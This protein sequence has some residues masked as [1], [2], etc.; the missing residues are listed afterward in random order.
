MSVEYILQIKNL[1]KK[2]RKYSILN[3]ISI[4]VRKNTIYALLGPNGAG[5]STTLKIISG[6]LK[7]TSGELIFNGRPWARKDL[8]SIGSL[9]E[10]APLY[11]NLTTTENLE[12]IRTI[13]NL[14]KK[15]IQ[16]VLEIVGL[17]NTG[18]KKVMHFSMG[19]KQRLGIA[20]AILNQPKLLILD[21][22]TNGLDPIGIQELRK[23]ITSFPH[24]GITVLLSSHLLSEV[25]QV[26][27]D[28][29]IISNGRIGYEG[30]Y[31]SYE[32]LESLFTDVVNSDR[33]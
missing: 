27:D 30:Q 8:I 32:D 33:T 6:L 29:G 10:N 31:H 4:N 11:G 13:L 12:V 9:I 18:N 5:K 16:E 7:E 22:P 20:L 19:M 21:E 24:Q 15:R 2:N 14:P 3:N 26:A 28:I 17:T 23:L 1:T 25:A